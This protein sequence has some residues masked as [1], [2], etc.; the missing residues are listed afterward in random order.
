MSGVRLPEINFVLL[1]GRV[2]RDAEIFVTQSGLSKV[3]VRIAVNRRV[4]DSKTGEWK[5][6]A[7]YIDVVAWKELAERSKDKAKKG[8]A[9]IV[10]GRLTCREYD[11]KSGQK[12]T[13]FEV[14]A[15]RIQFLSQAG[16][17]AAAPRA[18]APQSSDSESIEE[19]PF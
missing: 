5:D 14:M 7:F 9:L 17:A 10:E 11:D 2:T 18:A 15:N 8:V 12:R 19:V 4:K 3:T 6:D 13:I 16:E 1:A